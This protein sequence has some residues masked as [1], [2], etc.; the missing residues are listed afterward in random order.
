ME[1][2]QIKQQ[3]LQCKKCDLYKTKKNYVFGE[4]NP[5]TEIMFIGEAPG[6]TEDETGRPF[7]GRAGKILDEL[8][9]SI[10]LK[11]EDIFIAN[12]LKCRPPNNRNPMPDEIDACHNYL[13]LQIDAIKPKIICPL[14]NFACEYIFKKYSIIQNV[15][16]ISRLHGRIIKVNSIFGTITIIPL[17]HPAVATYNVEMKTILL[18]DIKMINNVRLQESK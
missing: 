10:G 8:L 3:V 9:T 12:V 16:G 2:E 17:Y 18:K 6:A 13:S 1:L 15:K 5:K 14:G 4:G 11:R 7:V